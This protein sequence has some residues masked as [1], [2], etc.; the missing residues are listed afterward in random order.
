MKFISIYTLF[1]R[2]LWNPLQVTYLY[3]ENQIQQR[4]AELN[5]PEIKSL[6]ALNKDEH[7]NLHRILNQRLTMINPCHS[8]RKSILGVELTNCLK[9]QTCQENEFP[10]YLRQHISNNMCNPRVSTETEDIEISWY[11]MHNILASQSIV[12]V[13]WKTIRMCLMIHTTQIRIGD[14]LQKPKCLLM[15]LVFFASLNLF[16][17]TFKK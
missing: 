4:F 14:S 15:K 8:V 7:R 2:Q 3:T 16:G 1:W 11:R 9:K 5:E 12:Y 6:T 17:S 13:C 10:I